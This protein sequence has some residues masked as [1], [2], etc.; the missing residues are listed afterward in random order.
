MR[1][2]TALGKVP[3]IVLTILWIVAITN[4]FNFLDNMDGLSAGVAAVCTTAFLV[5][6][7]TIHQWFVAGVAGAAARV[8]A[9][10]PL[11]QL[12]ARARFSWAT[13]DRW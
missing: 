13:A 4:A 7:L 3:S 10:I 2:L 12:P 1:I 5:T 6:T 8:A 11:L 9:R